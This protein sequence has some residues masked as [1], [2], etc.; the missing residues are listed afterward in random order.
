MADEFIVERSERALRLTFNRPDVLNS[1]T[2]DMAR[3]V[4]HEIEAAG[5]DPEIQAIMITGA[6][7]A[8]CTGA[9]LGVTDAGGPM[10]DGFNQIVLAIREVPRPV[11][12]AVNGVAAGAGA[13]IAFA[14]DVVVVAEPAYFVLSFA[15]IG[16]MP[17]AGATALLPAAIGRTRAARLALLAERLPSSTALEWGLITEVVSANELDSAA[18]GYLSRLANG[19]TAAL[20]R[21]KQ[22][23]NGTTLAGLHEAMEFERKEQLALLSAGDYSEGVRAFRERRQPVFH[24]LP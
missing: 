4:A 20:A 5:R 7:R 1:M 22:A 3:A 15:N 10:I 13:C 16:L 21:T 2:P 12:A 14:C 8:F 11:I 6:G 17:D 24:D 9:D 23:L 19:P 18:G